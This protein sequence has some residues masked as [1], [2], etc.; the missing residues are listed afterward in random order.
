MT[1]GYITLALGDPAYYT[2]AEN[3]A[4]SIKVMDPD[5][6]ICLVHDQDAVLSPEALWLFDHLIPLPADPDYPTVVNKFKLFALS[7]YDRSMFVDADCLMVK[8]DI[9]RYW[10]LG[11][12]SIFT[13][14]GAIRRDGEWKGRQ[15]PDLMREEGVDH[16]VQVNAGVF[17]FDK[18]DA[19]RDFFDGLNRFYRERKHALAVN[20]H[21][22]RRKYSDE[23]FLSIYMAKIGMRPWQ[24]DQSQRDSWMVTTYR[25]LVLRMNPRS[26]TAL[27]VKPTGYLFG[28]AV[29]PTGFTRLSPTFAHFVGLKPAATYARLAAAFRAEALAKSAQSKASIA[30]ASAA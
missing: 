28:I 8:R 20:T 14:P 24:R 19:C 11:A 30:T 22:G 10:A 16:I 7:P 27:I 4:A 12:G 23:M 25:S 29:L 17:C 21:R 6:P 13:I 26:Q 1:Q 9:D 2:M 3:L 5:R 15:I 18:S